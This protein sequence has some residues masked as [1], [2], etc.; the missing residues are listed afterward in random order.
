MSRYISLAFAQSPGWAGWW[1]VAGI[2][3]VILFAIF[4]VIAQF[5]RSW[6]QA[7][8]SNA[9]VRMADLIGMRLRKVDAAAIVFAKVQLVKSGIH[10]VAV[11]DVESHY[12]AGGRLP[13]VPRAIIAAARGRHRPGLEDA[14]RHRSRAFSESM[15]DLLEHFPLLCS[16]PRAFSPRGFPRSDACPAGDE[17]LH[18]IG[19]CSN[20]TYACVRL[21]PCFTKSASISRSATGGSSASA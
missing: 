5:F 11:N 15:S 16:E 2:A 12:L 8:M 9:D 20:P 7:C 19:I 10:D 21:A 14:V 4:V 18:E 3:G 17:P 6:L 1:I 13:D